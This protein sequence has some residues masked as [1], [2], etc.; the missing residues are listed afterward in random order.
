MTAQ[1]SLFDPPAQ[2]EHDCIRNGPCKTCGAT[3]PDGFTR[4]LFL[5]PV[6]F[7][8]S[9]CNGATV[10]EILEAGKAGDRH[11]SRPHGTVTI[12]RTRNVLPAGHQGGKRAGHDRAGRL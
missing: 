9:G 6:S 12:Q 10:A 8:C 3:R 5:E 11:G 7:E 4:P 1:L 2:P